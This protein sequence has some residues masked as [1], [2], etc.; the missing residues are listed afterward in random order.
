MSRLASY[1]FLLLSLHRRKRAQKATWLCPEITPR[2]DRRAGLLAR[3]ASSLALGTGERRAR[4]QT[5][6][7]KSAGQ[8]AARPGYLRFFLVSLR[9]PFDICSTIGWPERGSAPDFREAALLWAR[10]PPPAHL[11]APPPAVARAPAAGPLA[12]A[13]LPAPGWQSEV[14]SKGPLP[15]P[16]P[17]GQ[18]NRPGSS[19]GFL[20]ATAH[21]TRHPAGDCLLTL[22]T[23]APGPLSQVLGAFNPDNCVGYF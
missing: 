22:M 10:A 3:K 7:P 14:V 5:G 16:P 20:K 21:S 19:S 23:T 15:H 12:V 6:R 1:G 2:G 9:R 4:D 8:E 17:P 18:R 13:P 11:R